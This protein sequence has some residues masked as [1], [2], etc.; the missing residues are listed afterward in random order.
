MKKVAAF[1]L[2]LCGCYANPIVLSSSPTLVI[3]SSPDVGVIQTQEVGQS[4]VATKSHV[5]ESSIEIRSPTTFGKREG[6]STAWTCALTVPPSTAMQRGIYE[7]N[8]KGRMVF[9]DCYGPLI[10]S[11]TEPNGLPSGGCMGETVMIDVCQNTEDMSFFMVYPRS[12]SGKVEI[13]LLQDFDHLET[14]QTI[15]DEE[16]S[17]LAEVRYDGLSGDVL[18]FTYIKYGADSG[19]PTHSQSLEYRVSDSS[20]FEFQSLR[21]EIID[22]TESMLTYRVLSGLD[23]E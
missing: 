14:H 2:V 17:I 1:F 18:Q 3:I 5:M 8:R 6:D 11:S 19:P 23:V 9:A 13:P 21:L 15:L 16:S 12:P 10:A 22:A 20:I 7:K 4:V